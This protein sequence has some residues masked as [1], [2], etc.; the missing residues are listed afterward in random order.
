MHTSHD[1][2]PRRARRSPWR[3][4]AALLVVLIVSAATGNVAAAA[5]STPATTVTGT[6][7]WYGGPDERGTLG[8][9]A[10]PADEEGPLCP[11]LHLTTVAPDGSYSLALP[12]RG[13]TTW[14]LAAFVLVGASFVVGPSEAVAVPGPPNRS[15]DL[16]VSVRIV[17][18]SVVDDHDEPFPAGTAAVMALPTGDGE[19]SVATADEHGDV[20]LLVDPDLEY[21][22]NAFATGTGWPD[23]WVSDDGTEFHFSEGIVV[24]G[25]ELPEGHVFTV[26]PPEAVEPVGTRVRVLG[27]DGEPFAAGSAGVQAC[28]GP[29][30]PEPCTHYVAGGTDADGYVWLSLEPDLE[31]S[32]NAFAIDTGWPD[33]WVADDGTELHFSEGIVVLG[34]ELPEDHVFTVG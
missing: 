7:T 4:A 5:A 24:L 18:L 22:V 13:R 15:V 17:G 26:S 33:P 11:S 34:S 12:A 14:K 25:S 19:W 3:A 10:C 9:G 20:L 31:Y 1:T 27:P 29:G 30:W 2:R 23:P 8:V 32:V 16:T 28:A 6:V 21:S